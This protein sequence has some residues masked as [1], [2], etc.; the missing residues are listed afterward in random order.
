[1]TAAVERRARWIRILALLLVLAT[2]GVAC[3]GSDDDDAADGDEPAAEPAGGG[4]ADV[5]ENGTLELAA[6]IRPNQALMVYDIAALPSPAM[7]I[8]QLIYDTLLHAQMDGTFEP[9]IATKAEVTDAT[10][11]DVTIRD[12][13]KFNDGSP[14]TPE[15]VR[16][17]ILRNRD[18]KNG[19]FGAELQEVSDVTVAGQV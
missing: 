10:T 12:G 13:V 17:S 3:G 1:M 9:G 7:D 15:D 2:L 16:F 19:S 11:I 6:A 8:H 14:L 4:D 18:S 5:D